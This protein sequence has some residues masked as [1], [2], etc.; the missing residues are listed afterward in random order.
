VSG[1]VAFFQNVLHVPAAVTLLVI[2][3]EFLGALGLILGLG[4]R[5]AAAGIGAV[6]LGAIF[7]AH[8]SQGFFMDWAGTMTGEGF[9]YHLLVLGMVG[10]LVIAGGGRAS[11]D[12]R[13][14]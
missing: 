7:M 12:R 2:T 11:V 8:L 3:A 14:G 5:I 1:T 10:A 6:M 13:L 9:E 4:T